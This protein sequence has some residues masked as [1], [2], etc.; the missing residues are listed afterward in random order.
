MNIRNSAKA[1]IVNR[2]RTEVLLTKNQDEE[3]FFFLFPGGGQEHGET[4]HEAL[5]REC[6][7]EVGYVIEVDELVHIREYIGKNHEHAHFDYEVHQVEYYFAA[8]WKGDAI[9]VLTPSNPDSHQVGTE[10]VNVN[11]LQ[12]YRLYPKEIRNYIIKYAN[13]EEAPVYLGDV[14]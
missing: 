6:L 13:K 3:G 8:E 1:I 9:N 14:N 4:L 11:D 2:D 10:W 12:R 5:K 7:E